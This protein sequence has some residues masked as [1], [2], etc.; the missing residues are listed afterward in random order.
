MSKADLRRTCSGGPAVSVGWSAWG[1]SE[2]ASCVALSFSIGMKKTTT[3]DFMAVMVAT[4][5]QCNNK[6][7]TVYCMNSP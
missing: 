4:V 6:A 1:C 7:L 5:S 2:V 3:Q